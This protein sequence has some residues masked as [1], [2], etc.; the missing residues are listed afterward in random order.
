MK[1]YNYTLKCKGILNNTLTSVRANSREEADKKVNARLESSKLEI[2]SSQFVFRSEGNMTIAQI[3]GASGGQKS[4]RS[5][6]PEQ[7]AKMQAAR[8]R[9][10][11]SN[12]DDHL[13]PKT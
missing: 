4:K 7:Q 6:T 9:N 13:K 3:C 12:Y 1:T 10:S 5:I 11:P 2:Q 8:K